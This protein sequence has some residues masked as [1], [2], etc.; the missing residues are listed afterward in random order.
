VLLAAGNA[1]ARLVSAP[2]RWERFVWTVTPRPTLNA[3]PALQPAAQWRAIDSDG[4][5][6]QAWWR[7]ERQTF[8]PVPQSALAV[9]TILVAC[10]PLAQAI[11]SDAKAQRLH[12]A[13]ASMSP[14]VLHYRSLS[15]V[16]RPL[17]DWLARRTAA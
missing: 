9:F 5:A 6:A 16:Q 11:D 12:D 13:I 14:A 17:L 10:Q 4:V 7:T 8:I 2:T 1:L 3:H 15:A